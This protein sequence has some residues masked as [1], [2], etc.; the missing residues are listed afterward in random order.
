MDIQEDMFLRFFF[1][2]LGGRGEPGDRRK[3][4]LRP[5]WAMGG[6]NNIAVA[7]T[8]APNTEIVFE[9]GPREVRPVP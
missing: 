4:V 7:T 5:V 8:A 3:R 6:W 2:G 9:N 1:W